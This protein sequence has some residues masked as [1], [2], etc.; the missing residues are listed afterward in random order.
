VQMIK[1][2]EKLPFDVI[3]ERTIPFGFDVDEIPVVKD[4]LAAMVKSA[5]EGSCGTI[6]SDTIEYTFAKDDA[7]VGKSMIVEILSHLQ[8]I[9][10]ELE[11]QRPARLFG[12]IAESQNMTAFDLYSPMGGRYLRHGTIQ[13]LAGKPPD[14]T[15]LE[16]AIVQ[17]GE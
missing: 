11:Q 6:L 17:G 7:L 14:E 2:V 3:P 12:Q 16:G 15:G 8:Q 5:E 9:E 4:R 10:N 13:S 1:K